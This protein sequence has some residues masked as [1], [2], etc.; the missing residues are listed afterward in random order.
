MRKEETS[1]NENRRS[2]KQGYRVREAGLEKH[3]KT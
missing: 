2:R 1:S 3:G